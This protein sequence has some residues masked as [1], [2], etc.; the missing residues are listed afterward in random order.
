MDEDTSIILYAEIIKFNKTEQEWE[1]VVSQSIEGIKG[2]RHEDHVRTF[3]NYQG[4]LAD[5]TNLAMSNQFFVRQKSE[6]R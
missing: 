4:I 6:R 3:C 5:F 1:N 2:C